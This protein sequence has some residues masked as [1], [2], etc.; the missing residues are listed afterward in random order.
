VPYSQ[1][2]SSQLHRLGDLRTGVAPYTHTVRTDKGWRRFYASGWLA[3]GVMAAVAIHRWNAYVRE[4]ERRAEEA[5]RTRE[6][7]ARERAVEERLRIARD[8]HDSLTHSM[9]VIKVQSGVAVHLARKRGEEVPEALIAIQQASA[10]A[11]R[12]LRATLQLLRRPDDPEPAGLEA[13]PQLLAR[14]KATDLEVTATLDDLDAVPPDVGRVIYRVV[15]E[16]L[17]NV[18]RHSR[19]QAATVDVR[20]RPDAYQVIVE[21]P[22]D[23]LAADPT[24]GLGLI[25]MR[26]RVTALGGRLVAEPRPIGGFRVAAELPRAASA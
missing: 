16:A 18:A 7:V 15:Q 25:G 14:A 20:C 22:G 19:S 1:R 6:A 23:V 13:L 8:L 10:D 26:E 5:E 11:T 24:P 17:T 3:T 2:S 12:E 4:V 9:S 21:N